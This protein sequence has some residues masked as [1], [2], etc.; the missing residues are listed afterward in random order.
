MNMSPRQQVANN[1]AD[2]CIFGELN[3]SYGVSVEKA[4]DKNGKEHWSVLFAKARTLD[5]VI[6]VYSPSFILITWQGAL[7]RAAGL[8]LSGSQLCRSEGEAKEF[9]ISHFI[10]K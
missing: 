10:N 7:A 1:L 5:G 3:E 8:P 2:T 9:L 4:K 6:R